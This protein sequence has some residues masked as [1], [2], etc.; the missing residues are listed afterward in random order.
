[1]QSKL[2][3]LKNYS[4]PNRVIQNARKYYGDD[5][6][7]DVSTRTNKKWMILNPNNNKWVHFGQ[8]GY[9]DYT[10]HKDDYRRMNYLL[11]A[12]NIKGDWDKNPY[13]PNKLSILILWQ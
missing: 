5:V 3:E 12:S 9:E 8:M 11:R 13:S 6:K 1:M 4:N 7:I 10:K 2:N